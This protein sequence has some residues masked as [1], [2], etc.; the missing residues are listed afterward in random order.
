MTL[1]RTPT[2][3]KKAQIEQLDIFY[4]FFP[5]VKM[6]YLDGKTSIKLKL[7]EFKTFFIKKGSSESGR[8]LTFD[9]S[10]HS[11]KDKL[12]RRPF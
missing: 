12:N 4:S 11:S 2:V 8:Y 10:V 6:I 9:S 1:K 5:I 7:G 3:E